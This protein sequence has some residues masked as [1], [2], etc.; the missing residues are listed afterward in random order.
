MGQVS[1]VK[2]I[3]AHLAA[4]LPSLLLTALITAA[5]SPTRVN[6]LRDEPP[7]VMTVTPA[8]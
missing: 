6:S 1:P 4:L 7:A 5:L 8:P 2:P 3:R